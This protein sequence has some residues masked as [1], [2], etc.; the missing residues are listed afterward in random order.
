M[1]FLHKP[2]DRY[3]RLFAFVVFFYVLCYILNRLSALYD[4]PLYVSDDLFTTVL[5]IV[6]SIVMLDVTYRLGKQQAELQK[7]Q[8]Q[9][10]EFDIYKEMHRDIYKL[11]RYSNLVL[12]M[13]YCY[14][15]S[16]TAKDQA[17]R[18]EELEKAFDELSDKI[19]IDEADFVLR[20]GRNDE[21]SDAYNYAC[22]VVYLLGIVPA[23]VK[24]NRP[25]QAD[26]DKLNQLRFKNCN[27]SDREW[28]EAIA[29]YLPNNEQIIGVMGKF[30]EEKYL[31][32]NA[33]DNL[34]ERIRRSYKNEIN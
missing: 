24:D 28:L 27:N 21:I 9:I 32:F 26:L 3:L 12:P 16:N 22:F 11:Q 23:Y 19:A 30:V 29:P 10:A 5:P 6:L 14:F 18:V 33:E 15:A 31:L 25:E 1:F 4:W 20:K 7:Q 34:L 17:Q 8:C 13:I 2:W